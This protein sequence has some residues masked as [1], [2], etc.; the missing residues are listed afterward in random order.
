MLIVPV[1]K[2]IVFISEMLVAILAVEVV[3]VLDVMLFQAQ[4]GFELSIMVFAI[5]MSLGVRMCWSNP[6]DEKDRSQRSQYGMV[7]VDVKGGRGRR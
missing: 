4:P 6:W 1:I 5:K 7:D 2:K 3:D